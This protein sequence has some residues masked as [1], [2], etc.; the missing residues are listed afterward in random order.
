MKSV[1]TNLASLFFA[2]VLVFI[3]GCRQS[4]ST[5]RGAKA[6]GRNLS[7]SI[8]APASAEMQEVTDKYIK[9][10]IK[11]AFP[12]D[13]ISFL[14]FS[15]RQSVLVQTA[16]GGGPDILDLDG[17]TDANEYAVAG[18]IIDLGQYAEKYRW[19]DQFF[20]W[21]YNSG[22]YK[23]KIY[24]LP[25]SFEGLIMYYNVDVLKKYNVKQPTT[26]AEMIEACKV[27]Q[28][29]G[30]IPISYG[31]S[32]FQPAIDWLFSMWISCYAG[33]AKTK[34][35]LNGKAKWTDP[36]V[37]EAIWQM[38]D[39]WQAGYI[40]DKKTQAITTDDMVALFANGQAAMM[41]NGTWAT[42]DLLNTYP[43]CNWDIDL[44][45][46]LRPGVG[47][48]FPLA[49]GGSYAI[50]TACADKDFAAEV[51]NWIFTS[52][53]RHSAHVKEAAGQP[54]PLKSI[55]KDFFKGMDPKMVDMYDTLMD[56]Q[57][58][59]NTG[60]CSWTFY[61]VDVEQYMIDNTDAL[62]LGRMSIADYLAKTQELMEADI[63]A[64]T[65]NPVN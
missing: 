11:E 27:F 30:I 23:G 26:A 9:T 44:M 64:G 50:N 28:K 56:A 22:Y 21:A 10:P 47:R 8:S 54:Y 60:Y 18:R 62:F 19:K 58:D 31:Y 63:K 6:Q 65:Y 52:T 59:G 2:G 1:T 48:Y 49:V 41:L 25:N 7:I 51:L 14:E 5:E 61:P 33:P 4:Q 34:D 57:A 12:N 35:V 38:V 17:P 24:S 40:G 37:T 16:G 53:D 13:S 3:S 36:I 45:P 39:W 42:G 43:G 20:E 29:N 15:D 55:T 46:E 32:N